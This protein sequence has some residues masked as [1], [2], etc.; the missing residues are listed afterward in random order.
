[1][2]FCTSTSKL[3]YLL[4]SSY[5]SFVIISF[6]YNEESNLPSEI[7]FFYFDKL[8]KNE[9]L[10][11]FLLTHWFLIRKK[12]VLKY[13]CFFLKIEIKINYFDIVNI[14]FY[15]GRLLLKWYNFIKKS[16]LGFNFLINQIKCKFYL[17]FSR[18]WSFGVESLT[19]LIG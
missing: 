2:A 15:F 16:W 3:I 13:H 4:F 19:I 5:R 11:I 17:S 10:N 9:I 18:R 1:M 7:S 14:S 12:R 8:M 6:L